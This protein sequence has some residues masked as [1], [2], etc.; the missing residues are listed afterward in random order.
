MVICGCMI[1]IMWICGVGGD[2]MVVVVVVGL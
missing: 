2:V 1:A